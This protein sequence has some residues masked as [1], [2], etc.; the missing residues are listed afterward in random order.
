MSLRLQQ[1]FPLKTIWQTQ[2]GT[3]FSGGLE[4]VRESY[5]QHPFLGAKALKTGKP[6]LQCA[7]SPA[8][9]LVQRWWA[10]ELGALPC[11]I[12]TRDFAGRQNLR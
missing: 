11:L 5:C 4:A 7:P 10:A 2:V 3:H 1:P 12:V 8:A 6:G 9:P